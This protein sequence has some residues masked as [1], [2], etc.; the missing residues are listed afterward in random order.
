MYRKVVMYAFS[1][2]VCEAHRNFSM[3][4]SIHA[5]YL[6]WMHFVA[7]TVLLYLYIF[8]FSRYSFE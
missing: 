8:N 4:N 1:V 3:L 6:L 5:I 7:N 2:N